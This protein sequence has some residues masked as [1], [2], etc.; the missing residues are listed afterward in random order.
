MQ[1]SCHVSSASLPRDCGRVLSS[2]ASASVASFS[3]DFTSWMALQWTSRYGWSVIAEADEQFVAGQ[4]FSGWAGK[5]ARSTSRAWT[6][7]LRSVGLMVVAV[8]TVY[9]YGPT[10]K[11]QEEDSLSRLS[12]GLGYQDWY[13]A[14]LVSNPGNPMLL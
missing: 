2:P 6:I 14:G 13:Q 4:F 10:K 7:Q 5:A 12:G 3:G 11:P 1:L 8:A 9:R